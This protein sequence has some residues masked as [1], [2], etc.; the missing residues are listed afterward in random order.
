MLVPSGNIT[1]NL[2]ITTD[3]SGQTFTGGEP[4]PD[5]DWTGSVNFGTITPVV[6]LDSDGAGISGLNISGHGVFFQNFPFVSTDRARLALQVRNNSNDTKWFFASGYFSIRHD[7]RLGFQ[8]PSVDLKSPVGGESFPGGSIVPISWTASASEGLRSFDIQGSYDSGRT[9][10]PII[11]DLPG[12][13]IN[14]DWQLPPSTGIPDVRVRIVAR[15]VRFQNSSST[16]GAFSITPSGPTP[17]P[18]ATPTQRLLSLLPGLQRQRRHRVLHRLRRL[19]VTDN[20]AKAHAHAK[21]RTDAK[22][23]SVTAAE[24][25][26]GSL[27]LNDGRLL[28]G[29]NSGRRTQ[30]V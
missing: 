10:H 29:R 2:T 30:F 25:V 28:H 8:P 13:A 12:T 14:Y 1:G 21:A 5:M 17:T 18:T 26:G 15:D 22:A 23:S 6:V 16:S 24:T 20:Y 27:P 3:L 19:Q 11:R 4:I 7:S 9:W